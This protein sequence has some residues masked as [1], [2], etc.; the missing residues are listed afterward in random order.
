[1]RKRLL[2]G[3]VVALLL[4]VPAVRAAEVKPA[5]PTVV[6]RIESLEDLLA[7]AR[8]LAALAGQDELVK[9]VEG[10]VKAGGD[11][12]TG[13][14]G[15]DTQS[16]IG[17]YGTVGPQGFD[18]SAVLM[19]PV[20]DDK[21]FVGLL[22]L[23]GITPKRDD[24]VY[25]FE[26]SIQGINAPV[27]FR[28]ANG[29]AYVTA[30]SRGAIAPK[31]L[32]APAAVFPVKADGVA[33]AVLHVD[34]ISN[35]LKQ[36]ALGQIG[37]QLAELRDKRFPGE[38]EAETEVWKQMFEDIGSR[39]RMLLRDGK[40]V[41]L[42][43]DLDRKSG[44]LSA[45]LMLDGKPQSKLATAL[46]ELGQASSLFGR[47]RG[48]DSAARTAV[49]FSLPENVRSAVA[50]FVDERL[51]S[52]LQ[53]EQ[54][55]KRRERAKKFLTAIEPTLKSGELDSVLELRPN[56]KLHTLV[57][58]TKVKDG[59]AAEKALR[60]LLPDLPPGD[61]ARIQLDAETVGDVKV[62]RVEAKDEY[63]DAYKALFGDGPVYFAI[64]SDA[65]VV[66]LGEGALPAL[67]ETLAAKP[68]PASIVDVALSVKRLAPALAT[69]KENTDDIV[70]AAEEVFTKDGVDT[71][72]IQ[73]TGGTDFKA[74]IT[75]QATVLK[76]L[77][78]LGE[79][80][81]KN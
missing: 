45:E 61:R 4:A 27:Y 67:Q 1:M 52:A 41:A 81:G 77:I 80:K 26:A 54:D 60:E 23:L 70:K 33:S 18:S 32:L 62:H 44:D 73:A 8:F 30:L 37:L 55:E 20:A 16:P 58:G 49:N 13:V 28:F 31:A 6:V 66:T 3:L 42:R 76:F 59:T 12:K 78:V 75:L 57:F 17:F 29:Y 65:L 9:Q 79:K 50:A 2:S 5:T 22:G 40:D 51:T 69:Q 38:T 15:L 21:A 14:F 74:K 71:I 24:D 64:R 47:V 53:K 10:M 7:D 63:D 72:R 34:Q 48:S 43:L 25:S 56:G 68:G 19:I 35:D 46:V 39:I 36:L 11:A